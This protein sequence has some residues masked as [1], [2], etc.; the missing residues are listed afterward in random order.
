MLFF[1]FFLLKIS[2]QIMISSYIKN[3][4]SN[5]KIHFHQNKNK[6]TNNKKGIFAKEIYFSS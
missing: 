4:A 5:K 3:Q 6:K 2:S 1:I